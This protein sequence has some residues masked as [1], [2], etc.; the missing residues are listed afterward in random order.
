MNYKGVSVAVPGRKHI[1]QGI[2]CQ[3]AALDS[4]VPRP[5]AVV[6]DG[7]G[8][9]K[10]SHFGA[11]A[12]VKALQSQVI[13]I[14][15]ILAR[16][17]DAEVKP[18]AEQQELLCDIVYRAAA[19]VQQE[20]ANTHG[21]SCKAYEFTLLI[22]IGG[23][24][25]FFLMQVGDGAMVLKTKLNYGVVFTEPVYEFNNV[26]EFVKF[27]SKPRH[28]QSCF[29]D[30]ALVEGLSLFSDGTAE[31]MVRTLTYEPAPALNRIWDE[32]L[33][34]KFD[35]GDL[36]KYLTERFWDPHVLDDRSMAVL[37][38]EAE[39][40]EAVLEDVPEEVEDEKPEEMIAIS[41]DMDPVL[42]EKERE[43]PPESKEVDAP[44]HLS[45]GKLTRFKRWLFFKR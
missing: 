6:C 25:R 43:C 4:N 33:L 5:L 1:R 31:K 30:T 12:A 44:N 8:S 19:V 27:G 2:P 28:V 16:V 20:L 39:I 21:H 36:R 18:S 23:D 22:A 34:N 29:V 14:H 40:D 41:E 10:F 38:K 13:V 7:R 26:T 24:K 45:D 35:E 32:V 37:V 42:V 3:D 17:L 9:A 15:S 11:E